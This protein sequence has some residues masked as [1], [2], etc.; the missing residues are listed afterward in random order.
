VTNITVGPDCLGLFFCLWRS[1][2]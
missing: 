2:M 1:E